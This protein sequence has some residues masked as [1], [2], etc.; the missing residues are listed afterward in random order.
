MKTRSLLM[1]IMTTTTIDG[2]FSSA[3]NII[4]RIRRIIIMLMIKIVIIDDE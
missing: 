3:L 1:Q 4:T 2:K